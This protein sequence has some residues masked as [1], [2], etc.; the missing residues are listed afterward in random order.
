[1]DTAGDTELQRNWGGEIS[2]NGLFA[3]FVLA[4]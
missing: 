3:L 4:F 1:M 2:S